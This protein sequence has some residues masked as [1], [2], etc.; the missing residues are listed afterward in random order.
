MSYNI[1][2]F[3]EVKEIKETGN[4]NLWWYCDGSINIII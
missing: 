1:I 2:K 4:T 3:S